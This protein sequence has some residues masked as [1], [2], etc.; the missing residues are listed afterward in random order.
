MSF[1]GGEFDSS[2]IVSFLF[3]LMALV[4]AIL[5]FIKDMKTEKF[6]SKKDDNLEEFKDLVYKDMA[7]IKTRLNSHYDR[8]NNLAE[9]LARLEGKID[10]HR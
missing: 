1:P 3:G 8:A 9:R 4:Y 10:D 2:F 5:K 6:D 7:D